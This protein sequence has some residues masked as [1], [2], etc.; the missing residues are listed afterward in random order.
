MGKKR[1]SSG[2]GEADDAENNDTKNEPGELHLPNG[3]SSEKKKKKK[4]RQEEQKGGDSNETPTVSV[5]VP[6]SIIHNAQS[7]ELATRV[8]PFFPSS[9]HMNRRLMFF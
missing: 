4:K 8:M 6:G 2:G 9:L 7:L 5:A 1:K 3:E